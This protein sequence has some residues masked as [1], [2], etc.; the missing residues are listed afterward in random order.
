MARLRR[1]VL[2]T[3]RTFVK[4]FYKKLSNVAILHTLTGVVVIKVADF[5]G[6]APENG[7]FVTYDVE[8]FIGQEVSERN[9]G[10]V[11]TVVTKRRLVVPADF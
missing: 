10:G 4:S 2:P 7:V 8:H 11:I 9:G 3:N 1:L 6:Q 5:E